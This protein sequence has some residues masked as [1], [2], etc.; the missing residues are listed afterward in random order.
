MTTYRDATDAE[1][2]QGLR[3][4]DVAALDALL[5]RYWSPIVAY[6]ARMVDRPD[7]AE[8]IAQRTF[9]RLWERRASWRSK[10]SVRGLL[11]RMA[12]NLAVSAR[13]SEQARG[14]ADAASAERAGEPVT[15]LDDLENVELRDALSE[16]V[17]ALPPRRRE[18][19]VLRCVHE[20]SYK[21]IARIMGI[22]PQ[23]VANQLSHALSSLRTTLAGRLTD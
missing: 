8:D 2:L 4:D 14:R 5:R 11:Y 19:F 21:E 15:P 7:D 18:V 6:A 10:G 17:Q 23:T 22:S 20:L 1:L 3:D 13:R 16:A 9:Q 12:H